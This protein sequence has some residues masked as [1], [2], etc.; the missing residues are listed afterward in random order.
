LSCRVGGLSLRPFYRVYFVIASQ[1][2]VVLPWLK[3]GLRPLFSA[4]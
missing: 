1:I 3:I 2:P 4:V